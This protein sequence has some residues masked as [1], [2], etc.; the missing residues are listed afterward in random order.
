M[1]QGVI[2][3]VRKEAIFN[4]FNEGVILTNKDL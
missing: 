2:K 1:L 3:R 4:P